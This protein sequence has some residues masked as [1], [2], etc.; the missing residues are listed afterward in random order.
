MK[1][2]GFTLTGTMVYIALLA[3]LASILISFLVRVVEFNSQGKTAGEVLDS[4]SHSLTALIQEVQHAHAL[5]APTSTFDTHPGQLSLVTTRNLPTDESET[6]VDVY[7][8]DER[9]YIKRE[10]EAAELFSSERIRIT[11]FTIEAIS[12]SGTPDPDTARAVRLTLEVEPDIGDA[13]VARRNAVSLSSIATV[14]SY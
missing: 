7:I 1:T 11:N 4:A 3:I 9:L 2:N 14:R 13:E 10:G 12:A 8:D 5:Y 6:Y